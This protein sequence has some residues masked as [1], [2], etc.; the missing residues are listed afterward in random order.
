[1]YIIPRKR[2][3]GKKVKS[4]SMI[5]QPKFNSTS[6]SPFS[7]NVF[8]EFRLLKGTLLAR[9]SAVSHQKWA[10]SRLWGGPTATMPHL[11]TQ[12]SVVPGFGLYEENWEGREH[13]STEKFRRECWIGVSTV[14]RWENRNTFYIDCQFLVTLAQESLCNS[15]QLI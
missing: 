5:F 8:S 11:L 3:P 6:L 7:Y 14:I 9:G 2:F 4:V 13:M 1:M 15:P 10:T 12:H